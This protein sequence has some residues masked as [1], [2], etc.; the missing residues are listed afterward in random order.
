MASKDRRIESGAHRKGCLD[1]PVGEG[2]VVAPS[3]NNGR[4]EQQIRLGGPSLKPPRGYSQNVVAAAVSMPFERVRQR[5]ADSW[6]AQD[7]GA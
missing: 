2:E 7:G 5:P 4:F 1:E 6:L 3:R